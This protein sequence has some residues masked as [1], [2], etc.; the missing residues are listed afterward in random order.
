MHIVLFHLYDVL[1]HTKIIED[2]LEVSQ[3]NFQER[4]KY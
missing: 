2:V 4:S 3:G 1:K